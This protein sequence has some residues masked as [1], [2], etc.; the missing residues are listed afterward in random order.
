M[1][2]LEF[3][4]SSENRATISEDSRSVSRI[5]DAMRAMERSFH[6]E[7]V[8]IDSATLNLNAIAV[9]DERGI[10]YSA[11]AFA[12]TSTMVIDGDLW[13]QGQDFKINFSKFVRDYLEL[14]GEIADVR[15]AEAGP[16]DRW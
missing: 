9:V 16:T 8:K 15:A 4:N 11:I 2:T 10:V 6:P 12:V 14:V 1:K 5:T 13:L 3:D 7:L